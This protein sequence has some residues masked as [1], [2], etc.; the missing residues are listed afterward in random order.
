M[1]EF[2]AER[3]ENRSLP[4]LTEIDFKSILNRSKS[5][6]HVHFTKLNGF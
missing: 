2:S 5:I 3:K 4:A 1:G 6:N